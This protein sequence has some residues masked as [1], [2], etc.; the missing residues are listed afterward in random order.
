M[1][2]LN[3]AGCVLSAGVVGITAA[4][5]LAQAAPSVPAALRPPAGQVL[6]AETLATG[7][8]IYECASKAEQPGAFEWVFRSP[9]AALAD[10][11]GRSIGKH[12]AGPTWESNDGS[13]VSGEVASRDPGP[14]PTAIP[15]LLLKAKTHSGKGVFSDVVSIQRLQTAGGIA[16]TEACS[17][18]NL[19]QVVR[20]PYTATYYFYRAAAVASYSSY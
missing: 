9:E 13:V 19:K 17:A 14:T 7:V 6:A 3:L 4:E 18:A 1:K 12:Y 11:S 2:L 15:W 20:V 10:A 5:A 8:Q 16:P